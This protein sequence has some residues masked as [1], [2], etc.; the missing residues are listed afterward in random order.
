MDLDNLTI[1]HDIEAE[2]AVLGA[3]IFDNKVLN[4]VADIL[5]PI[6]F[7]E[8]SHRHVFRAMLKLAETNQP[9]DEILIGDQLKSFN[10]LEE[11]GGYAY[12]AEIVE[13]VPSSGNTIYYSK[14]IKEHAILRDLIS[15]T[16]EIGRKARDPQQSVIG[17]LIEAETKIQEIASNST[18]QDNTHIKEVLREN[19]QELEKL[20][21][22]KESIVGLN[23]GFLDLDKITCGLMRGDLI[24][25]AARPGAGKT[26]LAL[27]IAT[28][29]AIK[30]KNPG[31][32]QVFSR[33]MQKTK[34]SKRMLASEGKVNSYFLKTGNDSD[35]EC[36]DK[37]AC[38]TNTLSGAEIYLNERS[39]NIDEI[40]HSA[41]SLHKKVGLKLVIVDYLQKVHGNKP[42]REQEVSEISGK[43]KD[44]AKDLNI[45][46]I[47]PTQLN[48]ELEKRSDK[49]PILSDLRESGSIEQD[50]DIIMFIY[51]DEM[52]NE[53]SDK[54][55]IAEI[56]IGKNRDGPTGMIELVFS[57]KYTKFSNLSGIEP[58]DL[59]HP[60]KNPKHWQNK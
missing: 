57:G 32:V 9:I 11:I 7:H 52:Y 59:R 16:S 51:R 30:D 33:E 60:P 45:P 50:A 36:W 24:I 22:N 3:I 35:P 37:L 43:L 48:R 40:V 41:K 38:A 10:K 53:N 5:T 39:K 25:I 18:G 55:G 31:A 29:V 8:E 20:S 44:L 54:K 26:A 12:L 23:T 28:Y 17:L 56:I 2:Q 47:V 13:C 34:L 42:Y 49:R 14:I 58:P 4:D 46:V 27:N 6:S 15:I 19:F 1:P 21:G